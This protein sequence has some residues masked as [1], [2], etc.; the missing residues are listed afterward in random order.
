MQT[1]K[2]G[3]RQAGHIAFAREMANVLGEARSDTTSEIVCDVKS[4]L[5]K[6]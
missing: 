6:T 3:E 1:W 4:Q 5:F 2:C